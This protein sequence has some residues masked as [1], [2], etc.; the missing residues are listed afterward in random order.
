MPLLMLEST[1]PC[2]LPGAWLRHVM[3]MERGII[4]SCAPFGS[5]RPEIER[6]SVNSFAAFRLQRYELFCNFVSFWTLNI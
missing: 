3:D 5:K 4:C 6:P 1:L 2:S